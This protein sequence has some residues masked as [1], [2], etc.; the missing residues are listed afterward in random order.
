MKFIVRT[1][2]NA[3]LVFVLAN[4]IPGMMIQSFSAALFFSLILGLLNT[5]LKPFF[6]ILTIPITVLTFGVF[7]LVINAFIFWLASE[8]SFGV[9]VGSVAAAFWCSLIVGLVSLLINASFLKKH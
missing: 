1:L 2:V 3:L 9:H 7:V 4:Y 6:I 8:I 5:L